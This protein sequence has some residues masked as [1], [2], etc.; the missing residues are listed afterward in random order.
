M[1]SKTPYTVPFSFE[2]MD[3]QGALDRLHGIL[4]FGICPMLETVEE[5]LDELDRPDERFA[6]VQVAGTNGKTST[7][8]YTAAILAGEGLST[9]LYTSP[10]LVEY[11]E[12]MEVGGTP[13]T[14][15]QFAYGIA[16]AAEAGRRVNARRAAA[17]E[18][19]YDV[20]EFDTLTVAACVAFARAGVDVAVLEVGMGGRWDATTATHPAATCVTGIGLDHTK[21]LGDT[22][23]AIAG[24]KAAVIK[25]GQACVLGAGT[26]T[27]ASVEAVLLA[28]C[29]EQGVV[30]VLVRPAG[31]PS[32]QNLPQANYV[33]T[34]EPTALGE[35]LV[36]DVETPRATYRGLKA[37]KPAYQAQNIACA[38][39]L[40]EAFLGRALDPHALARSVAT[41]PTPGRFDVV[42]AEPLV[43]VD[44]A[45]NPQSVEIFLGS[46]AAMEPDRASRPM[47]LAAILAD[48]DVDSIVA[49][50]ADAF[51]RVWVTQT[52]SPRALAADELAARFEAAGATVVGVSPTVAGALDAIGD[53]PVVACGSITLAG[54]VCG[55]LR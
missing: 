52:S 22:L 19:P 38:V 41:C 45:H 46:L 44:A 29:A 33:L 34:E 4:R 54:E 43:L 13:V 8:R 50:L 30:P 55:L 53:R 21:I 25:A 2:P 49:L 31:E 9:A 40:V 3:Y 15:E 27:P 35:P 32:D 42:R 24:E 26:A 14:P 7:S 11:T 17:G 12:R 6:I 39:T 51:P 5:M 37:A 48:K 18:R 20:T 10:E 16:A 28:R 36:V 23:E 47:L 1:P